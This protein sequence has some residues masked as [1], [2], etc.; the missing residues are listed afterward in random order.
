M[1]WIE[2][3]I[4]VERERADAVANVFF[5]MGSGV[6][7]EEPAPA[8]IT[9]KGYFPADAGAGR[10]VAH[11]RRS[12]AAVV[13]S[14]PSVR[15]TQVREEDWAHAWRRHYH[16]FRVC[17]RLVIRPPWEEYPGFP[18]DLVI[19]LDPGM[20]FG[21][22]THPTTQ[23]CLAMLEEAVRPGMRV[24]DV[25]T[26]SGVLAIAAALLGAGRVQ[27]VDND[28]TAVRVAR[29]NVE[30]NGL[31]G[32]V[33]VRQGYLLDAIEGP[34]DLVVANITADV[35]WRLVPA[36]AR[37]LAPGGVFIA[38][39]IIRDRMPEVVEAVA[40]AG[41]RRLRTEERGEW[42]MLAGVMA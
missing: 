3:S 17:R 1:T 37:V 8:L 12:V 11:L 21:C 36:A 26:G 39:G 7:W 6:L 10:Q 38:G 16:P 42:A 23:M 5:E 35:V 22:G 28:P 19:A 27:A 32:K 9:V 30:A 2:V 34:L 24:C 13:G 29:K 18:D 15:V 33:D 14:E 40:G 41:W 4:T 25:G 20:A 31:A